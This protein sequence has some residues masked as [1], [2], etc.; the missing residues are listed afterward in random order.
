MPA[1]VVVQEA[2]VGFCE[3]EVKPFG[4]L[5]EY[6]VPATFPAD[7]EIVFPAQIGLLLVAVGAAGNGLTVTE[8]VPADPVQPFSVAAIE[9]TPELAAVAAEITGF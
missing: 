7:K 8:T 2:I 1:S 6:D 9:Y 5:Q 4:P 3:V